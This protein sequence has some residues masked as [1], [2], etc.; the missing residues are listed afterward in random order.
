MSNKRNDQRQLALK[1]LVERFERALTQQQV[2]FLSEEQFDDLLEHYYGQGDYDRTLYLADLAISQHTFTP[3]FYKWK[4]LIH[5]INLEEE[6]ALETLEKLSIYAPNDEESLMLRLEV[7]IHFEKTAEAKDLL[8][9]MYGRVDGVQKRSLLL[10]FQGLVLVQEDNYE[11]AWT[12]LLEAIEL[13]PYQEPALDEALN[14]VEFDHLRRGLKKTFQRIL[15]LDPFNHLVWYYLGL[16]YDDRGQDYKALD[17]FSYAR[18]LYQHDNRYELDYA[19]KLFDLDR[20]ESALKAYKAYFNLPAAEASYETFMRMGRSY[21]MLDNFADAKRAYFKA[22]DADPDMYDTH[23]HLGE[24]FA[25]EAK[26]S[27]AAHHYGRAVELAGH[28]AECWLG[29]ALCLTALNDPVE[30]EIAYR[31]ALTLDD[32]YSDAAVSYAIFLADNGREGEALKL[33]EGTLE[34]YEDANLA[35]G[36]VAVHLICGRRVQALQYLNDAL[37]SYYTERDILLEWYPNLRE[38]KEIDAIFQ[39]HR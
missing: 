1:Q 7:L 22:V 27:I 9:M 29:Y 16:W 18:S 24:C 15:N 38:D 12:A 5:K 10:F 30:A 33:M 35:Y 36:L 8:E 39:L 20:Y 11:D 6:D 14:A 4:A 23:Q 2:S 3:E 34:V 17:A 37:A 25:A 32:R 21:Q 26:W 19:D 13:D 31:R 28:T